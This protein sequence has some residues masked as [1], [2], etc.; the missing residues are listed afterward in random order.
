M[1]CDR[2]AKGI[3]LRNKDFILVLKVFRVP[4]LSG[5]ITS[6]TYLVVIGKKAY[7]SHK[8]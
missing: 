6:P 5:N 4:Q 3:A 1:D 8:L 7:I 2:D